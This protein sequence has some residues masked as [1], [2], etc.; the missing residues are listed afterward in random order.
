MG[1]ASLTQ[2]DKT[3]MLDAH[4]VIRSDYCLDPLVWSNEYSTTAQTY[5]DLCLQRHNADAIRSGLGENIWSGSLT[6]WGVT[7]TRAV[8]S[9]EGEKDDWVCE[10]GTSFAETAHFIQLVRN[11]T[12][13][14]G[15]GSAECIFIGMRFL[16]VV[17]NYFTGSNPAIEP[18]PKSQCSGVC[19]MTRTPAPSNNPT[20]APSA[21]PTSRPTPAPSVLPTSRP[22]PAPS[23]LP[24]SSWNPTPA[25]S[26]SPTSML[27]SNT[28]STSSV[29][30]TVFVPASTPM[31]ATHTDYAA[32][33]IAAFV[34][35]S[36]LPSIL[37]ILFRA[38]CK[39]PREV[40]MSRELSSL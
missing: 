31:P 40:R 36:C 38:G 11:T 15:C 34:I 6:A 5:A 21:L 18:F 19:S 7:A 22:T 37:Y 3:S 4:N 30:P 23:V 20:P 13:R 32:E 25:P 8:W 33:A 24:T 10:S 1:I 39:S 27:T 28:Q 12:V 29:I 2:T 17:C 26:V 14:V 9:W 16:H 35:L